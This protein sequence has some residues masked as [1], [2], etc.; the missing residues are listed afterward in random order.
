M[1]QITILMGVFCALFAVSCHGTAGHD[2]HDA[3][4]DHQTGEQ[5][6]PEPA[7]ADEIVLSA[8]KARAAG[9]V[10][11]TVAAGDF[12]SV[13]PAGGAILPSTGDETSVVAPA[14]GVVSLRRPLVEGS[15]IGAGEALFTI[16]SA[17]LQDGDPAERAA[18]AYETAKK[19]YERARDLVRDRIVSEKEFN[20]A[21]SSYETAKIAYEAVAR[22]R[23]GKGVVVAAPAGGRMTACLV[24]NGDYVS[25]GEPLARL[26]RHSRL[27]LRVDVPERY[28]PSLGQVVSAKFKPSYTDRVYDTEQMGGRLLAYGRSSADASGYVPVTFELDAG[29]EM[30]PGA[31]AEVYLLA[32]ERHGV[33]SLPLSAITEEQGVCF[34]YVQL[35]EAC[36]R[37]QEVQLGE[38][39]AERVEILKG[40][41]GGE[42]VVTQGAIHVKLA[43]A[44]NVIPAHTHNH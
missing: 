22:S 10:V 3:H 25:V 40:L 39:N 21:R 11:E 33:I 36:Y 26:A 16:S 4:A 31:F 14:P 1:K 34:V 32:G 18:V 38:S 24:K 19:E 20:A 15:A 8:D 28:Y 41:Q 6:E 12:R 44:G 9:V 23:T 29:E 17:N 27:F 7:H 42:R 43:S 35:D 5:H 37:R 2:G 30:L 13:I